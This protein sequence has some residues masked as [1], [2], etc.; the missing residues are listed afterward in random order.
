MGYSPPPPR[1]FKFNN[2][3]EVE[4][5]N[6]RDKFIAGSIDVMEFEY[7]LEGWLRWESMNPYDRR[8]FE[9]DWEKKRAD[10]IT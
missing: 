9:M 3:A 1:Q 8:Q 10:A 5:K 7:Q 6:L 4:I 2:I